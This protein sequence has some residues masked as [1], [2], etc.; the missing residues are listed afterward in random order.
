[1]T[2]HWKRVVVTLSLMLNVLCAALALTVTQKKGGLP[3]LQGKSIEFLS[4]FRSAQRAGGSPNN[5]LSVFEQLSIG[6][7]DIVFL[8]DSILAMGEWHELMGDP[9]AKNRAIGGDDTSGVLKRLDH[10]I[11]SRPAHVVLLIGI[12]NFQ[13]RVP[14]KQTTTEYAH[15]VGRLLSESDGTQIWLLPVFPVHPGLYRRWT[16]PA[17]PGVH[18]PELS[19]VESLNRFLQ[20]LTAK[21]RNRVHYLPIPSVLDQSGHLGEDFTLDGLHLNGRGLSE[22]AKHLKDAMKKSP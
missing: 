16:L 21:N 7:N 3:W 10:I 12:N 2:K 6:T 20:Q 5:R 14:F 11:A 17:N 13:R 22:I 4:F 19:E 8:G 18:M 15:I 1:M 9:R